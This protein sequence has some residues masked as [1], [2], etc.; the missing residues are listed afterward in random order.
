MTTDIKN[1]D[2][3]KQLQ[4]VLNDTMN[5]L[6]GRIIDSLRDEPDSWRGT[7]LELKHSS[8]VTL[9]TPENGCPILTHPLKYDFS[10]RAANQLAP[11]MQANIAQRAMKKHA[12]CVSAERIA[13]EWAQQLEKPQSI[14][15]AITAADAVDFLNCLLAFDSKFV[16]RLVGARVPCNVN[17]AEHPTVQVGGSHESE[18]GYEC[19]FLGVLNGLFGID[20][21]GRGPIRAVLNGSLV[22][23]FELGV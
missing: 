23:S 22:E 7:E 12:D 16:S 6:A 2:L 17:I 3:N 10:V 14:T 21:E 11:A 18:T 1:I 4:T 20:A 15:A 5:D 19:G 8:G 13:M 9:V